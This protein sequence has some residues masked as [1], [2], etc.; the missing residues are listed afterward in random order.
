MSSGFCSPL[1]SQ[2]DWLLRLW[3]RT[4]SA[5]FSS[6]ASLGTLL[7]QRIILRIFPVA[8]KLTVL[9]NPDQ[10]PFD[11][12]LL[13]ARFDAPG[14][15]AEEDPEAESADLTNYV[16]GGLF[17]PGKKFKQKTTFS[18]ESVSLHFEVPEFV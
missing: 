3:H 5:L 7:R 10:F 16:M 2:S 13:M 9:G 11:T 18:A 8:Q 6:T 12:Y 1:K 17:L 15:V 14:Y 4:T